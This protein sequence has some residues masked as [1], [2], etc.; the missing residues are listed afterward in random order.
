MISS[1]IHTSIYKNSYIY[2][3]PSRLSMLIHP[4]LEKAYHKSIDVDPY[5]LKKYEYLKKYNFFSITQS[6]T[7]GKIN[8]S[9]VMDTI[10][11][12][13]QI[14]FEVTDFCNLECAYCA[15]G[16]LY[17]GYDIRHQKEINTENAIEFLKYIFNL[18]HKNKDNKLFIG[19]Y[20]GEPLL[21][22]SFIQ[23]IVATVNELK[24]K[25]EIDVEYNLTTNATLLHKYIPFLAENNFHLLISLD[26]NERNHSYRS[27]VKSKKQSFKKVIEN[28]D[29]LQRM[30]PEYFKSRVNFNAVLHDRNSVKD[31][32]EFI[33]TRYNKIPRIAELSASDLNPEKEYLYNKM[34]KSRRESEAEYQKD[35]PNLLKE[36]ELS[37]YRNMIN[38]LKFNSINFYVSNII[39]SLHNIERK[40][41]VCACLPGQR[42]ILFTTNNKLLPCERISSKFSAGEMNEHLIIDIPKITHRYN[43]YYDQ[44]KEQCQNCYNS[45]SCLECLFHMDN[46]D[47]LGTE[48]FVCKYFCDSENYKNKL[49]RYFS[50]IEENPEDYV[51]IIENVVII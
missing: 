2:D 17:K 25:K 16:E 6:W 10:A 13:P 9:T 43:S 18:K 50:F 42:K 33:Y 32:Y 30:Y 39:E 49:Y 35:C 51:E 14:V 31:I 29:L 46:F 5:Y 19:F 48:E 21:N 38:F 47:K 34:F 40:F 24:S 7:Y 8:E 22:G 28:V 1:I 11:Q 12:T 44:M 41:P 37:Y 27:F 45:W 36:N 4:E 3:H 15:Y 20:G 26:G 23:Q